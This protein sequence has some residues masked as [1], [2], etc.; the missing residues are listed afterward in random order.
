VG[1]TSAGHSFRLNLH[2]YLV[3]GV[4]RTTTGFEFRLA[5]AGICTGV[6]IDAHWLWSGCSSDNWPGRGRKHRYKH[7]RVFRYSFYVY[8]HV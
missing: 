8:R 7:R 1:I 2:R 5:N 4:G 3:F 6:G